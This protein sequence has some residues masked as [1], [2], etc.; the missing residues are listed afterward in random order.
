MADSVASAR[1]QMENLVSPRIMH[2]LQPEVLVECGYASD[3]ILKIAEE[4]HVDLIVMGAHC[5]S[6]S[7]LVA[8]LP[9]ATTSAVVCQAH[10]PVLTVRS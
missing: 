5:S 8:H 4:K 7:T 6:Q 3:A 10:C 9:W 2:E 1:K